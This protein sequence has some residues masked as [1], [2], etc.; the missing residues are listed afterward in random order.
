[1][2]LM[3]GMYRIFSLVL[4][5]PL[6][7]YANNFDMVRIQAC[8]QI[9]PA[10]PS[11]VPTRSTPD[12]PLRFYSREQQVD[13]LC[14]VS[15]EL[16]FTAPAI[17]LAEQWNRV[18]GEQHINIQA[19]GLFKAFVLFLT[20]AAISTFLYRQGHRRSLLAHALI[21]A[22]VLSDP[23]ITLYLNTFYSEFSAVYF[24][25]IALMG[26]GLLHLHE[27]LEAKTHQPLIRY[28][29]WIFCL[30]MTGLLGLGF[31]KPQHMPLVLL[32]AV[33]A[34]W[35]VKQSGHTMWIAPIVISGLIPIL[36]HF[37]GF[38]SMR[39]DVMAQVNKTDM[40]GTLL[41]VV[42]QQEQAAALQ[43]LKLPED[44]LT[45]AG[46]N[47]HQL[48]HAG[49]VACMAA[50]E[51][52]YSRV[53]QLFIKQ[54]AYLLD[55]L[56]GAIPKTQRWVMG[57]Y[58]QVEG[59]QKALAMDYC[60]TLFA[61]I[62]P[63]GITMYTA[64]FCLPAAVWAGFQ[65]INRVRGLPV[66][67][68]QDVTAYGLL[69]VLQWSVLGIAVLGDG[70]VDIAKHTHLALTLLISQTVLLPFLLSPQPTHCVQ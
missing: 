44:C 36:F 38:L 61:L 34:A 66:A 24:L 57:F 7:A 13:A 10:D 6:L 17:V 65:A 12:A 4:H 32:L 8:H 67:V 41:S 69:T 54:P 5:D 43:Q 22:C 9:W 19:I 60:W 28:G 33:V 1:M 56:A 53:L 14:L 55:M 62:K 68:L 26:L 45:V 23:G 58:G 59:R 42:P 31:S 20:A 18:T 48:R 40:L 64:F 35:K 52:R 21:F 27:G 11:I 3:L 46:S 25:Y 49:S 51:L 16:L 70:Y 29:F 47:W 37:S 63:L 2:L 15:S 39:D 30:T 50:T